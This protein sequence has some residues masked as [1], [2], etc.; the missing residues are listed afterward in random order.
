MFGL[1]VGEC[2]MRY[3][4]GFEMWPDAALG[5]FGL[6]SVGGVIVN[7]AAFPEQNFEQDARRDPDAMLR[8][9]FETL[10]DEKI[11]GVIAQP[12][13]MA[14]PKL[15]PDKKPAFACR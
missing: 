3:T 14:F 13:R 15:I 6:T 5:S 12:I 9:V 7:G 1:A 8:M 4:C 10:A 11:A 2:D